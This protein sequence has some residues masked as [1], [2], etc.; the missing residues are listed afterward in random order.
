MIQ[1]RLMNEPVDL[2][3]KDG[4]GIPGPTDDLCAPTYSFGCSDGD[5]FTDFALEEIQNFGSGCA[6]LTGIPGWSQYFSLGPA[7]LIPGNTHTVTM[8]TGFG[9][10][11]VNIWIDF[12]DDDVLDASEMILNDYQMVS[13]GVLY[14]VDVTI[15][16]SATPGLH[17]MRAMTV[18]ASSFTDPCGSYSFGEAEDYMVNV[19]TPEY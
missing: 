3:P 7:T 2:T 11:H 16:V 6:D 17:K 8:G 9:S 15:P 13:S 5:G 4:G 14:D 12:N 18:Y 10:Q 19:I 1:Q